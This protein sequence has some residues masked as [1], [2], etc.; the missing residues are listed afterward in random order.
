MS[1]QNIP[2]AD[3]TLVLDRSSSIASIVD[4][5]IQGVNQFL[6]EQAKLPGRATITLVQ[7]DDQYEV[8]WKAIPIAEAAHLDRTT[9]VPRGGTALLDAIEQSIED[10]TARLAAFKPEARPQKVIFVVFT[11]GY[12]NSSRRFSRPDIART[13]RNQREVHG[14]EFLF[15]GANQDAILSASELGIDRRS[16]HTFEATEE[17]TRAALNTASSSVATSRSTLESDAAPGGHDQPRRS[18]QPPEPTSSSTGTPPT[19]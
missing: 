12:E 18:P 16:A 15:L 17:G 13:I 6:D 8:H 7:F 5:V 4:P 9:L 11:D 10:T 1:Q 14:W 19:P 3:I 2:S